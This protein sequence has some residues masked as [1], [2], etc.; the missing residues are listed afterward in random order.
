MGRHGSSRRLVPD[1]A[2][3]PQDN[4]SGFTLIELVAVLAILAVVTALSLPALGRSAE[5]LRLRTEG[6]RIAA[7]LR[8]ARVQA[9]T[10]QRPTRVT[11]DPARRA[12]TLQA[13]SATARVVTVR[14]GIQVRAAA[15]GESLTFSSRG[16]ARPA[17]W[18]LEGPGGRRV[19]VEVADLGG[20]IT[21]A[22]D[23]AR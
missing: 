8:A 14:P 4:Q 15:G 12:V 13:G 23:Q 10:E 1:P 22:P 6:G 3:P 2:A 19:A 21:V 16:L 9:L 5:G 7:L 11:L 18:I 17:R 20:R